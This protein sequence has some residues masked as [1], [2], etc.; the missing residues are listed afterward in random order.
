MRGLRTGLSLALLG[1]SIIC[2]ATIVPAQRKYFTDRRDALLQALA[3]ASLPHGVSQPEDSFV[4]LS[5][6]PSRFDFFAIAKSHPVDTDFGR[7]CDIALRAAGLPDLMIKYDRERRLDVLDS[8]YDHS[9]FARAYA[10]LTLDVGRFRQVLIDQG[11]RPAI[12]LARPDYA[13]IV[14]AS[15]LGGGM[16]RWRYYDVTTGVGVVTVWEE[17][18]PLDYVAIVW[19]LLAVPVC[20]LCGFAW[21]ARISRGEGPTLD[22]QRQ[23][24]RRVVWGSVY[25][26]IAVHLPVFLWLFMSGSMSKMTDLWFGQDLRTL[27]A[28]EPMLPLPALALAARKM[29]P[30]EAK[31]FGTTIQEMDQKQRAQVRR[32]LPGA[33]IAFGISTVCMLIAVGA[34]TRTQNRQMLALVPLGILIGI[35]V[36]TYM[37]QAAKRREH[38]ATDRER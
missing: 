34:F 27:L 21:S 22:R 33:L 4:F 30:F 19:S 23:A 37:E 12:V 15:G 2:S 3:D 18:A 25:A 6:S 17:A 20:V 1:I 5:V 32:N 31:L 7:A 9:G 28:V 13:Q 14:G 11:Y 29:K 24:Y 35:A 10:S 36:M 26:G 38:E 16:H 8:D